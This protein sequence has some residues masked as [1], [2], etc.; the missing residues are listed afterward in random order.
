M[1]LSLL[2]ALSS[3]R[4]VWM[5]IIKRDI[6]KVFAEFKAIDHEM[7]LVDYSSSNDEFITHARIV[8]L[9]SMSLNFMLN[10]SQITRITH[11][12]FT[13][14]H[15]RIENV[16]SNV[17]ANND[18]SIDFMNI[19]A[20]VNDENFMNISREINEDNIAVLKNSVNNIVMIIDAEQLRREALLKR[21]TDSKDAE[22]DSNFMKE[23]NSSKSKKLTLKNL[24]AKFRKSLK[25]QTLEKL[26]SSREEKDMKIKINERTYHVDMI[27][28]H[29]HSCARFFLRNSEINSLI[30][31]SSVKLTKLIINKTLTRIFCEIARDEAE[32]KTWKK[33]EHKIIIEKSTY[34]LLLNKKTSDN[35]DFITTDSN[36]IQKSNFHYT[37]AFE[38]RISRDLIW[39]I[40][41]LVTSKI[42]FRKAIEC[43]KKYLI[44][45]IQ[46]HTKYREKCSI[47]IDKRIAW[48]YLLLTKVLE[49]SDIE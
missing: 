47:Y 29:L 37:N 49:I 33:S 27:I 14:E 48:K 46:K 30:S 2:I 45:K 35:Y 16:A 13:A 44:W 23:L 1:T 39:F 41:K 7:F 26:Q 18:E 28:K 11:N 20:N 31:K 40:K 4:F 8:H 25:N 12:T 21:I 19:A 32:N 5:T 10:D 17:I 24:S 9:N 38:S 6:K 43:A 15:E 34:L 36:N 42:K 22:E 3:I